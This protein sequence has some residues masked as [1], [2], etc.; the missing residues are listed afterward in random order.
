MTEIMLKAEVPDSKTVAAA[1][2]CGVS[3]FFSLSTTLLTGYSLCLSSPTVPPSFG[4]R[5]ASLS[6][7]P[8]ENSE[9]EEGELAET[10][11]WLLLLHSLARV[12]RLK[13]L[14]FLPFLSF[15]PI[16]SDSLCTSEAVVG[17]MLP[18]LADRRETEGGGDATGCRGSTFHWTVA[19]WQRAEGLN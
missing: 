6:L 15:F 18:F 8:L 5:C 16:L 10:G 2:A 19:M 4:S 17:P 14:D 11:L 13:P 12:L 1:N 9:R 7:C 3:K